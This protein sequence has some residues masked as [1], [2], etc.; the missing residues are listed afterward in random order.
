MKSFRENWQLF[1]KLLFDPWSLM[2][3][4]STG[5]LFALGQ[6]ASPPNPTATTLVNILMTL[7]S[8]V[9]GSRVTKL[10]MDKS[11]GN[12]VVARGE[13]AIRNLKLLLRNVLALDSRVKNFMSRPEPDDTF[14]AIT[15]RNYEEI[16]SK[17]EILMEE[18]VNSIE[19]WTDI[20]PEADVRTQIGQLSDLKFQLANKEEEVSKIKTE[21]QE[22]K[23]Q[24]QN[25][26]DKLEQRVTAKEVEISQLKREIREKESKVVSAIPVAISSNF[27]IGQGFAHTAIGMSPIGNE[28]VAI[29]RNILGRASAIGKVGSGMDLTGHKTKPIASIKDNQP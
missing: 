23:D 22:T 14:K 29:G 20:I 21:L 7:S 2:L 1:F 4:V 17:C 18:V 11:E 19:N 16:L 25:E 10:W 28:G 24:S 9:L 12:I 13:I 26:K 15:M 27:E 6:S 5:I 3:L 8:A